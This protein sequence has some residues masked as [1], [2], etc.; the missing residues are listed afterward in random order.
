MTVKSL[1]GWAALS[2]ALAAPAAAAPATPQEAKRLTT[3]FQ[4]YVGQPAAGKPGAVTVTPSGES[5]RAEFDLARL[6][7]PLSAFGL[8]VAVTSPY[9]ATLTPQPDGS[10]RVRSDGFPAVAFTQG[11]QTTTF[12]YDGY[13]YDG[14]F[15]PKL[16]AMRD[17]TT[18]MTGV[19]AGGVSPLASTQ[20]HYT[21]KVTGHQ[22]GRDAGD[23]S[24][25][26]DAH[27]VAA[28]LDYTLT[29][30]SRPTKGAPQAVS[31]A[32]AARAPTAS[33]DVAL[34]HV[35]TTAIL[36]LWAYLVAHPSRAA[37]VADQAGLKARL[38]AVLAA[39]PHGSAGTQVDKLAVTTPVGPVALGHLEESVEL[40]D[41]ASG[42]AALGLHYAGLSVP[43][44]RLPAWA[45]KLVPTALDLDVAVGPFHLNDGLRKAVADLDLA[46]DRPLSDA[47]V[48]EVMQAFGDPDAMVV[49]LSPTTLTGPLMT[50]KAQG[51]VRMDASGRPTGDATVTATGLDG[52]LSALNGSAQDDPTAAQAAAV[53]TLAKQA[54][55]ASGPDMYTW[56][57][58]ARP[59]KPV[60]VNGS[61]VAQP[62]PD[63]APDP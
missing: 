43:A 19:T 37:L 17:L 41:K 15:D 7:A 11:D 2:F 44:D 61:P 57:V 35:S 9:A 13:T 52:A 62:E 21:A 26:L 34:S 53:L 8:T 10:W 18:A 38:Q 4:R 28:D 59:G 47:Q 63:P 55:K 25:D 42:R 32:L 12:K 23:G 16:E 46:S 20:Q 31:F 14:V 54:G 27:Q 6:M 29:M 3:L 24:V 36:D 51:S 60:T 5:Y 40:G 48:G 50:V 39:D 58:E 33:S 22:T 45:V 49:T 56:L 30:Q 1:G